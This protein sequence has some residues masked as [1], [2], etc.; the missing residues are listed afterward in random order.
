MS[1]RCR[2]RRVSHRRAHRAGA[3]IGTETIPSPWVFVRP[4]MGPRVTVR[5]GKPFYPPK[6]AR[7][8]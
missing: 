6:A 1:A 8:T 3:I 4:F 5:V 2:G 7:I